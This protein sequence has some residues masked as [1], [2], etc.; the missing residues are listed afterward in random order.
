ML[1]VVGDL[2]Y[3]VMVWTPAGSAALGV[4]CPMRCQRRRHRYPVGGS[5]GGD[6]G[7]GTGVNGG[8]ERGSGSVYTAARRMR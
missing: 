8:G 3:T 1:L 7:G 6:R 4:Q 2:G 5:G